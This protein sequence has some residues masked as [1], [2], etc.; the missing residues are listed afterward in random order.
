MAPYLFMAK[1]IA[2]IENNTSLKVIKKN[3]IDDDIDID[4]GRFDRPFFNQRER[5]TLGARR[6]MLGVLTENANLGARI[7]EIVTGSAAE[8]A[9]QEKDDIITTI[10]GKKVVD[11]N[12]LVSIIGEYEA[13]DMVNIEISRKNMAKTLTAKLDN[14]E[15]PT[16]FRGNSQFNLPFNNFKELF[17]MPGN[18][19]MIFEQ[20]NTPKIGLGLEESSQGLEI[21]SIEPNSAAAEAGLE[22]GDK[23]EPFEGE[24]VQSN[25]DIKQALK[26]A[27]GNKE[28]YLGIKRND[29]IKSL[30]VV[31]PQAKKRAQF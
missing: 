23:I 22:E 8:K 30:R 26:R 31:L 10:D 18:G 4:I 3:T 25:D 13:G 20:N 15:P 29:A 16:V 5:S 24:K 1:K 6:A 7:K 11:Y 19:G 2:D 14:N 21:I 27:K 12:D 9:G 28:I 17:D